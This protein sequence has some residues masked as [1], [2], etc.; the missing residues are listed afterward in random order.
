MRGES[1]PI[2]LSFFSCLCAW[3]QPTRQKEETD[4]AAA[5]ASGGGSGRRE[6]EENLGTPERGEKKKGGTGTRAKFV[7]AE[8]RENKTEEQGAR[9]GAWI[10]RFPRIP[11]IYILSWQRKEGK[12]RK[13]RRW[14][15]KRAAASGRR[16]SERERSR[17]EERPRGWPRDISRLYARPTPNFAELLYDSIYPI[18]PGTPSCT[19]PLTIPPRR[20]FSE[21]RYTDPEEN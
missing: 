18:L 15:K 5:V 14:E 20:G 10:L 11:L 17:R 2:P 3:R 8:W 9:N 16:A 7:R 12:E 13:G 1:G 6:R 4:A 21:S 19:H